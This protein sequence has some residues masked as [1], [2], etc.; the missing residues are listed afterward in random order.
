M[1]VPPEVI[2]QVARDMHAAYGGRVFTIQAAREIAE[3]N[4]RATALNIE[5]TSLV[6]RK[7]REILMAPCPRC[8]HVQVKQ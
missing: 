8:G 4:A 6:L 5:E 1:K 3:A 7:A 2:E